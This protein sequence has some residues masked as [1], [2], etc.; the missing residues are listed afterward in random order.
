MEI[1]YKKKIRNQKLPYYSVCVYIY[2]DTKH[3]LKRST[4]TYI[5][6]ALLFTI[7]KEMKV[8][9]IIDEWI[10]KCR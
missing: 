1:P 6:I 8:S 10:R 4:C 2:M 9:S 7:A 3:I 5:V